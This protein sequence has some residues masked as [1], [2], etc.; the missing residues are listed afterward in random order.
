MLSP[1]TPVLPSAA[2]LTRFSR[3]S[4]WVPGIGRRR[5]RPPRPSGHSIPLDWRLAT[6]RCW[7]TPAPRWTPRL[8]SWSVRCRR[9][10]PRMPGRAGLDT[11]TVVRAAAELADASG[12]DSL[13]LA[14]LAEHLGV[15]VPSLYN[16]V[17]GLPGLRRSLALYG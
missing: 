9:E 17:E 11:A 6:G 1:P 14:G 7:M 5:W 13:T 16:H 12:L 10:A 3:S 2:P 8:R 15:R 4:P